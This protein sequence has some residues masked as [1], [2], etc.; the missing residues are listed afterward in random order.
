MRFNSTSS[1]RAR[2]V[3]VAVGEER[4]DK[5]PIGVGTR[6]E[7]ARSHMGNKQG[8]ASPATVADGTSAA[9]AATTLSES[10]RF[11]DTTATTTTGARTSVPSA[12]DASASATPDPAPSDA[13]IAERVDSL[14]LA[15]DIASPASAPA[16]SAADPDAEADAPTRRAPTGG[17]RNYLKGKPKGDGK[18][19]GGRGRGRR[20]RAP[21]GGDDTSA[22]PNV[23]ADANADDGG[24]A[25]VAGG[26]SERYDANL[27]GSGPDV[28]WE[29]TVTWL[30]DELSTMRIARDYPEILTTAVRVLEKWRASFPKSVWIRVV[31][32]GRLAKELNECAPVIRHTLDTVA[33]MPTPTAPERRANVVDLC[34]GF[35]YLGMFLAEMLDPAKVQRVILLDKQWPMF[36][37]APQ[38]H[39]I[40][41]DHVYGIDDWKPDWPIT[42]VTRKMDIKQAGQL[43]QMEE[44][45]FQKYEGPFVILA[46]HL[47]GTLSVKAVEMF[48]DHDAAAT[49]CLKPCC[50]PEWSHT[51][52]HE[53]WMVG[54]HCIPVA[55]VCAK[56][57]WK[58]NR[59][60]GPP[61]SHLREKF[62]R[63]VAHLHAAVD[64]RDDEKRLERIQIQEE[65]GHQ[66]D[67]IFAERAEYATTPGAPRGRYAGEPERHVKVDEA[68]ARRRREEAERFKAA[69][70]A[71]DAERAARREA[72]RKTIGD[73]TNDETIGD[74]NEKARE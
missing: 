34:S 73:E 61:R 67:F 19:K 3:A 37:M 63:W 62:A 4:R 49:L 11:D 32:A 46:V 71:K 23:D 25:M 42:L 17:K 70:D 54:D 51:Y 20:G 44:H 39:Q 21:R 47:C 16:S 72:R 50:L 53:A 58:A 28:P 68:K 56:G 7:S 41:W 12:A 26:P 45:V 66:N 74:E 24:V 10:E 36:G 69:K 15:H 1:R 9:S 30:T 6:L 57:K 38:P 48:N 5:T 59:W 2:R 35:G 22:D 52:T 14:S 60:I 29:D 13:A 43:R 33:A 31:K 65:G 40:N 64:V 27:A 55:D 8:R 18:E